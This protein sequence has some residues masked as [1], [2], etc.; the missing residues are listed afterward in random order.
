MS[1]EALPALWLLLLLA[2]GLAAAAQAPPDPLP[3]TTPLTAS[4]NPTAEMTAG[5]DRFLTRALERSV[6]E[7]PKFWNRDFSSLA[8]YE[9]SIQANRERLRRMIG[10][11]DARTPAASAD[12]GADALIVAQSDA[13]T[14]QTAR[15][16]VF[17]EV[18]GEGLLLRPKAAPLACIVAIP[19]ADQTPE[20]AAGL[21]PGLAADRQFARRLAENGCE[22]L[23]PVLLD[24][25]DTGSG[26][27]QLGRFTNQPHREWIYRQAFELGRHIIGY[28]A[29]KVMAAVDFFQDQRPRAKGQHAKIGVMGYAEGGLIALY[30]AALDPRIDA[31]LV[32]GYFDSRQRVWEEPIYRNVFGLLREFGDAEIASLITPRSLIIEHSPVPKIDG[33]PPPR[34]G[35]SGAAPGKLS[36][37]DYD[38]VETE[39]ERAQAIVQPGQAKGFAP[40]TLICGTEGMTCGPGSDRALTA[41]LNCLG[42]PMEQVKRPGPAPAIVREPGDPAARQQRQVQQLQEY[43]RKMSRDCERAR[44]EFFWNNATAG[45]PREWETQRV[46]FKD[47][48]WEEVLGRLPAPAIAPNPRS[49]R[50]EWPAGGAQAGS[51]RWTG[52]E[53]RLE[54]YPDVF[55]SGY[56]LVPQDLKPGERRP[57]IVCQHGLS[58]GP[59]DTINEDPQSPPFKYYKGFAARL[60]DRGFV[61][62][63]PQNPYR[64]G[65]QFR[66]LQRKANPLKLS[67]FS[68]IIAQH[69]R[70][71]DWL[72]T[73]PFVDAGR[74]GFYGLSYGGTTALRVPAV[75]ERYSLSIC[76]GNFN[77]WVRKNVSTDSPTSYMFH[78]EYEM[79][80]FDLGHSFSHA[81]MAAL[82]AP[83]PFMVERGHADDVG[84]DEWVA[85]EYAKVRRFYEQLGIGD[86]TAIEFFEGGHTI[87]GIGTFDFLRQHLAWPAP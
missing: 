81:E 62:F 87:N 60:A 18:Y 1:K 51:G 5:I 78:G 72:A 6:N 49:R 40:P 19:D 9:K 50:L 7:R 43:T 64:D 48:F 57:T 35:R 45:S 59:E 20:M 3:G 67:L 26:N 13:F 86:R 33:P 68:F 52:Y 4:T 17:P 65:D 36:T 71:L 47:L 66:P 55:A 85:G 83:R 79:P 16:P 30:S 53:V 24:R 82:I 23:V 75:L 77:D 11:A 27:P 56:L 54:V 58:S 73:L 84:V 69:S 46:H 74:I 12:V 22:V 61:V 76:S 2:G 32:S 44:A 28:E 8:A 80:E 39:C 42:M 15:W 38:S 14:V 10:A 37:P 34:P 70:L 29:Q 63:A 25:R 41:L 21:A 31:V